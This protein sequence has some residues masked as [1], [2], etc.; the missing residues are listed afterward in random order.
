MLGCVAPKPLMIA[1]GTGDPMIAREVVLATGNRLEAIWERYGAKENFERFQWQGGHVFFSS[2]ESLYG[3][4]NFILKHFGQPTVPAGTPLPE[5]LFSTDVALAELGP[6]DLDIEGVAAEITGKKNP[7]CRSL[8]D[9]FP[10]QLV[11]ASAEMEG[12]W[13]ELLA[14]Q[15]SFL[16]PR[17]RG[18]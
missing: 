12:S 8:E 18:C 15:E 11:P 14:Q 17:F 4:A 1:S 2:A 16:S 7:N 10:P 13:R 3:I 5:L 6:D 9:A